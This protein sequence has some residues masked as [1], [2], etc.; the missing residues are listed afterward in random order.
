MQKL[1][2][3]IVKLKSHVKTLSKIPNESKVEALKNFK[4]PFDEKVIR[5]KEEDMN[6]NQKRVGSRDKEK[7]CKVTKGF[8]P[9]DKER[10]SE[11]RKRNCKGNTRKIYW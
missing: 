1:N 2:D 3:E 9:R 8:R 7:L 6:R 10:Q 5:W 11:I 4:I